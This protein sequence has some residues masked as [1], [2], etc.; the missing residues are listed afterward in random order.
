MTDG[1]GHCPLKGA[2]AGALAALDQ[3]AVTS[4]AERFAVSLAAS[5][6]RASEPAE[7]MRFAFALP[8]HVL[9]SLLGFGDDALNAV[10][11]D[12]GDL[13][14]GMAPGAPADVVVAGSA[15]ADGL[16]GRLHAMLETSDA[17]RLLHA[18]ADGVRAIG[19]SAD[20]AVDNAIGLMVQAH[21]GTAGLI[22]N[23]LVALAREPAWTH[24]VSADDARMRELVD[25]VAR[26][27]PPV[28]NTRRFVGA[29]A[30]IAG[31]QVSAGDVILVLL[32]AANRDTAVPG[33]PRTP[34]GFAFGAG[35]HACPGSTIAA[36]I[37]Q[38]GVARL[39]AN[40]V[41][42]ARIDPR[43]PYRP[44]VNCRIPVLRRREESTSAPDGLATPEPVLAAVEEGG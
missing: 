44:S 26:F 20:V 41:D 28:Q 18:L 11:S 12:V 37:A 35:A 13:V 31:Q 34:A 42:P 2:V 29:P 24:R 22:G 30:T 7:C 5:I 40:G 15:A 6:G 38:V 14:R 25:R 43:P 33:D 17:P 23:T 8:S 32:A 10:A 9:E 4:A 16:R 39:L 36:T 1:A 3:A 27:D 21:D 19:G